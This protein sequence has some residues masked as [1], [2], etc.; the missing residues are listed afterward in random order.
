MRARDNPFSTDRLQRIRYRFQERTWENL[1]E[2][3]ERMHY[4]A[5]IVGGEGTGKTTFLEDLEPRLRDL[6]FTTVRLVLTQQAPRLSPVMQQMI[7]S[8][9]TDRHIILFDG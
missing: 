2:R 4:R 5:A 3:L 6:G 1:M 8:R 7:D 9:I